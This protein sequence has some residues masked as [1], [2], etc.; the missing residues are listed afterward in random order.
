MECVPAHPAE[1]RGI[2]SVHPRTASVPFLS[3]FAPA[4]SAAMVAA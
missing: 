4:P 3:L 1:V 2:T